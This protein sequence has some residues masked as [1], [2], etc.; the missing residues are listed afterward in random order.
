MEELNAHLRRESGEED[1]GLED[2]DILDLPG[3]NS[4]EKVSDTPDI[5][6]MA[7]G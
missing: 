4:V 2:R 1:D 6:E 5:D 7:W 3:M